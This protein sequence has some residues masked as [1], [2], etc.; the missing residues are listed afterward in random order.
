MILASSEMTTAI[1]SDV[2]RPLWKVLSYDVSTATGE[3]WGAIISGTASQTPSDLST[4]VHEIKWS[5]DRV[6]INLADDLLQFHPDSGS[7]VSVLCPGRAIRVLEGYEGVAE[8]QWIPIFSGLIQGPYSWTLMRTGT[9]EVKLNVFPRNTNEAWNRRSITSKNFTVGSD[10]SSMFRNVA[11]DVMLMEDSELDINDPW[12]LLF[13]KDMNQIVNISPWEGLSQLAQGNFLRLWFNG[14][15]QLST[16]PITLDRVDRVLTDNT[17][18]NNYAQKGNNTEHVNKVVVTYLDNVLSRV[19]GAKTVLGSANLTAGFF[20]FE[21]KLDVFYSDDKKKRADN[22]ELVVK[23]SIN[24]ND[25]GI[26][27][28]SERLDIKDEFGGELVITV[29]FWVSALATAGIAAITASAFI[30]DEA[31]Q[32][33]AGVLPTIQVGQLVMAAGIVAVMLA[34][35]IL[36]TGVYDI[37]GTPYDFAFLEKQAICML[38]NIKFWEEK[39]KEIR[40]DFISTESH[41]EQLALNELLFEQSTGKPRSMVIQN[42]PRIERGDI[43]QLPNGAKFF[44]QNA[45][46]TIGRG[47]DVGMELTGFRSVV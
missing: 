23:S 35:M 39:I 29:D 20:D 36:G 42:D 5:Y 22:V 14:K 7:L 43:L 34:M 6:T 27:V 10:W 47:G 28:G 12:N 3:T 18:Y 44:V 21:T 24:Q 40:N 17:T 11:Q 19:D 45:Q 26:S 46:K 1:E 38:D 4:F 8:D 15:G 33:P 41:A 30:P 31:P 9:P 16:Y 37:V 25:L 32:A 13:D 2:Q